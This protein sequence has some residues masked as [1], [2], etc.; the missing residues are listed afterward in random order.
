MH[1]SIEIRSGQST[2]PSQMDHLYPGSQYLVYSFR[3]VTMDP[4]QESEHLSTSDC[5]SSEHNPML[6]CETIFAGEYGLKKNVRGN[7]G[8]KR[9]YLKPFSCVE[10]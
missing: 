6:L 9:P 10:L 1:T 5:H 4:E 2:Y 7:Q 3:N 8:W